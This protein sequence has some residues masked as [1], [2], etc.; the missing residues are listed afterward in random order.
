VCGP[1]DLSRF[2]KIMLFLAMAD[3]ALCGDVGW[4]LDLNKDG[5]TNGFAKMHAEMAVSDRFHTLCTIIRAEGATLLP[6]LR[7]TSSGKQ[8]FG[9]SL[10]GLVL[11]QEAVAAYANMLDVTEACGR[12][13]VRL[14]RH[15]G[16]YLFM[17]KSPLAPRGKQAAVML[18]QLPASEWRKG[19]DLCR[20]IWEDV[21]DQYDGTIYH[22]SGFLTLATMCNFMIS[23]L[24]QI[25]AHVVPCAFVPKM[26]NRFPLPLINFGGMFFFDC[27]WPDEDVNKTEVFGSTPDPADLKHSIHAPAPKVAFDIM[28]LIPL[29]PI[30]ERADPS[31]CGF[32]RNSQ[33]TC[34]YT[35]NGLGCPLV[36][37][38]PSQAAARAEGDTGNSCYWTLSR[39][40]AG[41]TTPAAER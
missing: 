23:R 2:E 31:G 1:L 24:D 21:T 34:A 5:V 38:T 8:V 33:P 17:L 13:M 32:I 3:L 7:D 6:L 9:I 4:F 39:L 30:V 12:N 19:V 11:A 35:Q 18:A 27:L 40:K 14:S 20:Q 15:V 41:L 37:L 36:G 16:Q 28:S 22:L 26:T 29:M 25:A 10:R